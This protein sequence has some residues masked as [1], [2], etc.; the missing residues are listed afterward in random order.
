MRL[1]VINPKNLRRTTVE[2]QM[3]VYT[4]ECGHH[5]FGESEV[6]ADCYAAMRGRREG[7]MTEKRLDRT[8]RNRYIA[9]K[10]S[11]RYP[12]GTLRCRIQR[13]CFAA[14]TG[15]NSLSQSNVKRVATAALERILP[16]AENYL[17]AE[18]EGR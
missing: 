4:H 18:R 14:A 9:H 16:V 1:I 8:C 17:R 11:R 15:A 12:P 7:W 10:S 6:V 5:L 2:T 13:Y 3:F